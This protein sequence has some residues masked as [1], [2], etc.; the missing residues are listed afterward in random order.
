[1][2]RFSICT[3]VH[4]PPLRLLEACIRSVLAQRVDDWQW[5]IVDDASTD[6]AVTE[7][8]ATLAASDSRVTVRT[9][10][11]GGGIVAASN[12]TLAIAEGEFVVLL[13]HDD[14]LTQDAL[15]V[16]D[17]A[18]RADPEI[19]YLYSDED[20]I[21]DDGS[22]YDTFYKP[23]WSP[24]RL[25]SQNYCTH[26]SV[27]RRTLVAAV[28]GFR[29][30]FDGSQDHDL[31]LRVT[32]RARRVH[33]VPRVLY[34]WCVN[35][36]SAAADPFAKPYAREAGRR[37][38]SDQ[39][40][41][42]DV[43]ATVEHLDTPGHFRVRRHLPAAPPKVS[44]VIPTAGTSR[45]VWGL[46]RPLVYRCVESLLAVTD[47]PDFE[48]VVVTDPGTPA[49]V[50]ETLAATP[51]RIVE[52]SGPFNFS[53]RINLGAANASGTQLLMLNDDTFVEQP[54][55][56]ATMVGF[57]LERDVGV[58]GARLVY[59]DGTLQHGGI[60]CNAQ[61][62]HIFHGFAGDDAGPFGLLEI[63]R[64]VTAVTGACLLT[65]RLVF[66][67]IGG[68]PEHFA[69]AF[70]DLEYCLR[71][72]ASGRRVIWTAHA[73]LYHFESQTRAPHAEPHEIDELYARWDDELHH[74][75]Y[76]N[77][78]FVPMQAVWLP[79]SRATLRSALR[80]RLGRAR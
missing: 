1:V 55:W 20:K 36:G 7:R 10:V 74:D 78:N 11:A 41:R 75:P 76:G 66:D 3:P 31:I 71:V 58:V 18:L 17:E 60:L 42:L 40:E 69:V 39:L 54:D 56:L 8:L 77:P 26:L 9:R 13:D 65:P 33:H 22:V 38:V 4:D 28:G 14:R 15:A 34:H 6:P 72:R 43:P 27:L 5:C 45:M 64:E 67:E 23:D 44:I 52:A 19:D 30:G 47:Y 29:P 51:V 61:P 46:D 24:E 12:D 35:P 57:T 59:A 49:S 79:S 80:A 73:T 70:N 32:E 21:A 48:V 25:R 68:L 63:D 53:S 62:L 16:V 37:A 50:V 2:T